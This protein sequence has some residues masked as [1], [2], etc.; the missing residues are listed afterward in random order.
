[1]PD[2]T[3]FT[4]DLHWAASRLRQAHGETA[5]AD[6]LDQWANGAD[7]PNVTATRPAGTCG[8]ALSTGQP[9]PDHPQPTITPAAAAHVL[10]QE[11]QGGYPAGS[12]TTALLKAWWLADDENSLTLSLAF[13]AY[14]AAIDLLRAADGV[15]RL[16]ATAGGEQR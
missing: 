5:A 1:M 10:W 4:A 9:C 13:P 7:I 14:G 11:N 15:A 6:L 2:P 16:R 8:R 12:F 3:Q